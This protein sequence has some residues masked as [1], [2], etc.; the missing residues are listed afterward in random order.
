MLE[1]NELEKKLENC[2]RYLER[3]YVDKSNFYKDEDIGYC[4]AVIEYLPRLLTLLRLEQHRATQIADSHLWKEIE[5]LQAKITDLE[6]QVAFDNYWRDVRAL[7]TDE[8][9]KMHI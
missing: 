8:R 2:T 6:K 7:N 1:I 4:K 3:V 5:R 9:T